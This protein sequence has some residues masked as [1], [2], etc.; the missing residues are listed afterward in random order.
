MDFSEESHHDNLVRNPSVQLCLSIQNSFGFNGDSKTRDFAAKCGWI[1]LQTRN[2]VVLMTMAT[3]MK[4]PTDAT[5]T[6][7][8]SGLEDAGTWFSHYLFGMC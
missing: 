7:K 8:I 4:V 6:K 2:C 1:G 3:S 5:Q